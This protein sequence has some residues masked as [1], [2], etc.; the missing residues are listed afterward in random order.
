MGQNEDVVRIP[1]AMREAEKKDHFHDA[2][3]L[4]AAIE[5]I[6]RV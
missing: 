6:Y 3:V 5:R 4:E 2:V 1:R